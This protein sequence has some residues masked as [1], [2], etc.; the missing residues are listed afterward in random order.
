M[1]MNTQKKNGSDKESKSFLSRIFGESKETV[2]AVD[3]LKAQHRD[4][5]SLFEAIETAGDQA[6]L[7]KD[8]LADKVCNKLILHAQLEEKFL[9]PVV[10]T[11]NAKQFYEAEE[12][13]D[14]VKMVI[15]KLRTVRSHGANFA[16]KVKV[17]KELVGHHVKEEENEMFPLLK[18]ELDHA[19]LEELGQK[20]AHY[21]EASEKEAEPKKATGKSTIG[22]GHAKANGKAAV[23]KVAK[24]VAKAKA[25]VVAKAKTF[26]KSAKA[27]KAVI[28][29]KAKKTAGRS[30]SAAH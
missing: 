21:A 3:F 29:A 11:L 13:H 14:A 18:K 12:E 19:K 17:L 30:R 10:K 25:K 7:S 6:F 27:T 4:V 8:F 23:A 15:A 24:P 16:A 20:M 9:Y 2:N 22:N 26:A 5:E 1:D 28:A